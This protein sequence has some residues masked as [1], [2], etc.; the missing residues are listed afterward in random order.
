MGKSAFIRCVKGNQTFA[1]AKLLGD[2]DPATTELVC[3]QLKKSPEEWRPQLET[4]SRMDDE[5]VSRAA[6]RLLSEFNRQA[7]EEDFDLFCRFFP[8]QGNL[9]EACWALAGIL[10]PSG[11][12]AGARHNL[13]V[14]GR[15]LLLK[16]AGAISTRERVRI[17]SRFLVDELHFR[18]NQEDYY[19][20][21][22]SILTKVIETR[23]GL[24][25]TMSCLA[26]FLSHR[27][28]MN[29]VGINLP[30]H[31]IVRH[32]DVFFDPFHGG[33]I[34]NITD[35]EEILR[36]Q[37]LEPTADCFAVATP[38]RILQRMLCNLHYNY[39]RL[40][41]KDMASK[42]RTWLEALRRAN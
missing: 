33:R 36:C 20:P 41:D 22:N 26:I 40:H 9:E 16:I 14:W 37:G 23:R 15:M 7:A 21:A 13:T 34:L 39:E 1:L 28:G 29:V 38:R 27:A 18:G 24:P 42:T 11:D 32:S 19:N 2:G 3:Q 25:I 6:S 8:E 31:F 17:L 35:C 5:R 10:D 12:V 4:L 30:G